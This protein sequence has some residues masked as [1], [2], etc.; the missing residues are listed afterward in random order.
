MLDQIR[1][2]A[3]DLDNTLWD[4]GPIIVRAEQRLLEW[5]EEH[6]PRIPR[7]VSLEDMRAAR[8][9]LAEA[10]PHRA[11]DFTY[12]RTASLAR[13]AE[14][15]GYEP[16]IAAQAFEIFFAARND[17]EPFADVLPAL[18]RLRTRYALATLS[19]GNADLA[20]MQ[21]FAGAFKVS[22]NARDVG[23]AKPHPRGFERLASALALD[24]AEIIYVGDDPHHD[25]VGARAAGLQTAWIN[26]RNDE[27][28]MD[29][30]APDLV[31]I[32]CNDLAAR[33]RV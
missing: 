17:I 3:F 9:R 4:V 22:L 13:H 23:S 25:I 28:P 5:L 10:E 18:A 20:R 1:A 30:P 14:E 24:P 16:E 26:R 8:L 21:S 32:D 7:R 6:Y 12:L 2:V 19:N 33:L 27:W 31:V 29:A 11:H 15:S